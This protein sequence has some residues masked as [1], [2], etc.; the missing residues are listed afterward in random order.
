MISHDARLIHSAGC[1]LWVCGEGVTGLRVES[2][3][4]D[5]YRRDVHVAMDNLQRITEAK[6]K[7]VPASH[8]YCPRF[9]F[10]LAYSFCRSLFTV[11]FAFCR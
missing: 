5:K 1:E 9:Y 2:R 11:M 4:F 8:V 6:V 10:T 7:V 3:G